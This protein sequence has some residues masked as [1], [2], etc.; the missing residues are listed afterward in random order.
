MSI[1]ETTFIWAIKICIWMAIIM[2]PKEAIMFVAGKAADA[3]KHGQ[4]SYGG[5]SRALTGSS[6][7]WDDH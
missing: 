4:V 1:I 5:F 6:K 3:H 2:G 7:S